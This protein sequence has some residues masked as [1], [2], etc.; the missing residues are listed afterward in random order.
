MT[1]KILVCLSS[2]SELTLKHGKKLKTGYFINEV[3]VP[4]MHVYDETDFEVV[5]ANPLG[6]TPVMDP[7]SD[8]LLWFRGNRSRYNRAKEIICRPEFVHPQTFQQILELGEERLAEEFVGLFIPGGHAPLVDLPES[9]ELGQIIR[10]FHDRQRPIAM[11]CHGPVALLSTLAEPAQSIESF[12]AVNNAKGGTSVEGL[13]SVTSPT[14]IPS[15]WIFHGY[16]MTCFSN[17]EEA[18]ITAMNLIVGPRDFMD[19]KCESALKACGGKVKTSLLGGLVVE[20]RELITGQN[21]FSD[22]SLGRRF[23]ERLGEASR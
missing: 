15:S 13:R 4:L 22:D 2:S 10:F 11:I 20:D 3:A 6:N 23:V 14:D 5:F 19:L 21:P 1:K 18:M 12:R 16:K 9:K 17:L 7:R 8:S